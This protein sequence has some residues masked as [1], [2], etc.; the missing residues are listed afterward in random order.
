MVKTLIDN[1]MTIAI[2]TMI[3]SIPLFLSYNIKHVVFPEGLTFVFFFSWGLVS[4]PTVPILL[5]IELVVLRH[6]LAYPE[7]TAGSAQV[8]YTACAIFVAIAAIAVFLF[9]RV[10]N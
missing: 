6:L 10:A 5:L 1:S 9:V 3:M 8:I 2:I 4:V 7:A